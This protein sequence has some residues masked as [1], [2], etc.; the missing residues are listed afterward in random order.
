MKLWE[1]IKTRWFGMLRGQVVEVTMLPSCYVAPQSWECPNSY[2]AKDYYPRD[3]GWEGLMP[4]MMG[5]MR[6]TECY[7][8]FDVKF[9]EVSLG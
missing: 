7:T 3:V 5:T 1:A 8:T 6:C 9:E 4:G 2:C